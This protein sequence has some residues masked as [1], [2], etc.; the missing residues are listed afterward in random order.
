MLRDAGCDEP[1]VGDAVLCIGE[2]VTN[3][4]LHAGGAVCLGLRASAEAVRIEVSDRVPPTGLGLGLGSAARVAGAEVVLD[5]RWSET[6][7]GLR[8]VDQLASTWAERGETVEGR[9]G[10]VVWAELVA[11]EV[12]WEQVSDPTPERRPA[13]RALGPVAVLLDVPIRLFLRSEGHLVALLRDMQLR[14]PDGPGGN[15]RLVRGLTVALAGGAAGRAVALVEAQR[16]LQRGNGTVTMRFVLR[17]T[18]VTDAREFADVVDL[19]ETLTG[20]CGEPSSSDELRHFRR[21]YV[22]ELVHQANGNLPRHCP[23]RP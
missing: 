21:W 8:I 14:S 1:L 9:P 3:A 17:P 4:L 7:R 16:E 10:K 12:E 2:L 6:G 13:S 5:E 22:A 15:H 11:G 20:R 19:C 18:T 23:F